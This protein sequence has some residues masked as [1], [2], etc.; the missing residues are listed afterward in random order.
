MHA[1]L[2]NARASVNQVKEEYGPRQRTEKMI[3]QTGGNIGGGNAR[4]GM[5]LGGVSGPANSAHE[6]GL[7]GEVDALLYDIEARSAGTLGVREVCAVYLVRRL[8]F[9]QVLEY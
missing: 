1:S 4:H 9:T 6:A 8:D 5:L 3:Y 2:L 7:F